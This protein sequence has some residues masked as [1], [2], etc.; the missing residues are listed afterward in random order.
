MLDLSENLFNN[1]IL[2]SL[3]RLSNLKSLFL[4]GNKLEG[5][6]DLT[7]KITPSPFLSL[8][9]VI[10]EWFLMF[11]AENIVFYF[12]LIIFQFVILF[13]VKCFEQLGR[14]GYRLQYPPRYVVVLKQN[15]VYI[16]FEQIILMKWVL[17]Y[18]SKHIKKLKFKLNETFALIYSI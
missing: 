14:I 12:N 6:I 17:I 4:C 7:G 5:S 1:S 13:S 8:F 11:N 16:N 3:G 9:K 10:I 15:C 2:P 18:I